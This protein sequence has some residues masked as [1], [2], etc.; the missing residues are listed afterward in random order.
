MRN[1]AEQRQRATVEPDMREFGIYEELA[2][3]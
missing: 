3:G 1:R 2:H